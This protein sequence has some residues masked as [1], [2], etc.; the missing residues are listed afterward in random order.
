MMKIIHTEESVKM[1]RKKMT[2]LLLSAL[3]LIGSAGFALADE[4][5]TDTSDEQTQSESVDN[6]TGDDTQ[7]ADTDGD[8][9]SSEVTDGEQDTND[10]DASVSGDTIYME[11]TALTP[12]DIVGSQ[13][14]ILIDSDSGRLL[15]GKNIDVKLYPASMTKMMT[16]IIALETGDLA[17]TVT[18]PYEALQTVNFAEDSAM[19]LLTGEELTL[20]QLV[21]AMLIHSA[22]D[23]ANVIAFH[24]GGNMDAFVETM[25]QKAADLGMTNTHFVNA[26]GSHDDNHYTTARDMATLAQY[27]MKNE[28]FR[29][30]VKTVVYKIP[31]TN[32]YTLEAERTLVNTNLLLGTIR[33]LYQFY[34]PATGIKTGHTSQA[35]YCLAASAS[36]SDMNLIAVTMKCDQM[37]EHDDPY[38]YADTRSMFEFAFSNYTHQQLAAPGDI[39]SSSPVYEAKNDSRVALTIQDALTAL[40]PSN[41]DSS[42]D[43]IRTVDVPEHI[44]APVAK[45]DTIGAVTYTYKGTQIGSAPLISTND[46]EMNHFL[47]VFHIILKVLTSPF[48]FIPVIL[49]IIIAM[50]MRHLRKKKE[51]KRRIQQLK[52]AR[53]EKEAEASGINNANYRKT[54]R[55]DRQRKNTKDSNSRYRK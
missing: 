38:T 32:K 17:Q 34:A 46:V 37:D 36:F 47:H 44:Q 52:K 48:F 49:L 35:G 25:N 39:I 55:I 7:D 53:E 22:N 31:Q 16:A 15:Y 42:V 6:D 10:T 45:G 21:S 54:E 29:D 12:P 18:V 26:C 24:L 9:D 50:Y 43:I 3:L 51:R 8:S 4:D 14:A 23:A 28:K 40:V 33:S 11:D 30:I 27:C 1:R 20:E 2:A 5:N 19:G 13:A 41:I